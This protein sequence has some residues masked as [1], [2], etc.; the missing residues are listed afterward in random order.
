LIV[1]A[2]IA[3]AAY[4]C[5]KNRKTNKIQVE[6]DKKFP[7]AAILSILI[8]VVSFVVSFIRV[9][10][11]LIYAACDQEEFETLLEYIMP[12]FVLLL[13]VALTLALAAFYTSKNN[14]VGIVSND[15]KVDVIASSEFKPI[16][17]IQLSKLDEFKPVVTT[18]I[19][20]AV[21]EIDDNATFTNTTNAFVQEQ[22][23]TS[24]PTAEPIVDS[25]PSD[26]ELQAANLVDDYYNNNIASHPILKNSPKEIL[27]DV[28]N[29]DFYAVPK[30][31][32]KTKKVVSKQ[33]NIK[34][35]KKQAVNK[36][37][38]SVKKSAVKT[39]KPKV[40][41]TTKKPVL[42]AKKSTPKKK[43]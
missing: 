38:K 27:S 10:Y 32:E 18:P 36:K 35:A 7:F 29:D 31:K 8:I 17:N 20:P 41:K 3:I 43:K 34:P 39:S 12:V 14:S 37:A 33:K 11:N 2:L 16:V 21:K 40:A 23:P 28:V 6:K 24:I 19:I 9:V 5:L 13:F 26:P 30:P 4:G 22:I 42:K 15:E 1:F 25:I